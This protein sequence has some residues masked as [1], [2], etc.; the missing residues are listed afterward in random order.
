MEIKD[1]N[2]LDYCIEKNYGDFNS[3]FQID[4]IPIWWLL[5]PML[6]QTTLPAPFK[7]LITINKED[8]NL[9]Q[10]LKTNITLFALRKGILIKEILKWRKY[11]NINPQ[12]SDVLFLCYT[13]NSSE[14]ER[15]R[16]LPNYN[17]IKKLKYIDIMPFCLFLDPITKISVRRDAYRRMIYTYI[18]S[19][20]LIQGKRISESIV[21]NWNNI[22]EE[23]K[24]KIFSFENKNYWKIFKNELNFLFSKEMIRILIVYYLLFKKIINTHKIKV[25]YTTSLGGFYE[26]IA[27]AAAYKLNKKIVHSPHGYGDRYFI[28]DKELLKNVFF[29]CW[30]DLHKE[31]LLKLGVEEKKIKITGSP[32]F[33]DIVNYKK[34]YTTNDLCFLTIPLV[35][36]GFVDKTTYFN[37]IDNI[38][39]NILQVSKKIQIKTH[40]REIFLEEYKELLR[41][42]KLN[43][44]IIS[45]KGKHVLYQCLSKSKIV[46]SFGS[47]TCIEAMLLNKPLILME[48]LKSNQLIDIE[49]KDVYIKFVIKVTDTQGIVNVLKKLDDKTYKMKILDRQ[50]EYIRKEFY[51]IDGKASERVATVI[52]KI[53]HDKVCE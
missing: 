43:P 27:L 51:K 14:K 50:N 25:I 5:S 44:T 45:A 37:G 12:E 47:T 10:K 17:I 31:R 36:D 7:S 13:N 22:T 3:M 9:L 52:R 18:D 46:L 26:T 48:F 42:N 30:G 53:V 38:I 15:K 24:N 28:V 40:P 21:K 41:K 39:K 49:S 8:E 1:I 34:A 29:M 32:I 16:T 4:G 35:E 33:D 2:V 19:D 20:I 23:E 6:K 11:N